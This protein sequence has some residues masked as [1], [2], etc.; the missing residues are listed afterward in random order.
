MLAQEITTRF[1]G[2]AAAEAAEP[3]FERRARGGVPDEI[4]DVALAGAPLA[5]RRAAQAGR[6]GAV[7]QRGDAPGRSAAACASTARWSATRA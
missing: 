4:P 5:H 2:A 7:D 1:H 3:D 6:P